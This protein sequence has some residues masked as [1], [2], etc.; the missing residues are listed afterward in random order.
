MSF[1]EL[2]EYILKHHKTHLIFD[3]DA[4]MVLMHIDWPKMSERMREDIVA[5]DPELWEAFG[6]GK[7]TPL[8]NELMVRHGDAGLDIIHRHV[9]A[10]EMQYKDDY[11]KNEALLAEIA[12]LHNQF[13]LFIWSSN[14]RALLDD[15]LAQLGMQDWFETIVS[16]TSVRHAKPSPEGFELIRDPDVPLERY[17]LIGDSS[18]DE[19]AARA[20]GIDFYHHDFFERGR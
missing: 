18:H 8:L 19:G 15:V 17:I 2:S 9:P 20:A 3:F 6:G 10:F 12:K 14:S 4:T 13:H 5:L 7:N 1:P 11:A 16:R